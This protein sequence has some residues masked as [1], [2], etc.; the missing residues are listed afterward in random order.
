MIPIETEPS[1]S[2]SDK[3]NGTPDG[4]VIEMFPSYRFR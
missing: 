4:S 3:N 2:E 1:V